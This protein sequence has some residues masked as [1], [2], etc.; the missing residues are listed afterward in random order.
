M[1]ATY[2]DDLAARGRAAWLSLLAEYVRDACGEFGSARGAL[3]LSLS[4]R[5]ARASVQWTGFPERVASCLGRQ[6]ALE[7]LDAE[8]P[9]PG[10]RELQ[11]EYVEWRVVRDGSRIARIEFTTELPDYWAL[12]AAYNPERLL[13]LV[14]EFA[15]A[16][17][18]AAEVFGTEDA[19]GDSVTRA[20]REDTFRAV[21]LSAGTS[22]FNDGRTAICCM[23]QQ[24]NSLFSAAALAAASLTPRVV[25]DPIDGRRRAPRCDEA[26]SLFWRG[27][28]Q[29]GRASDPLLVER[30]AQL[31]LEGRA[32]AFD[33]PVGIY[34]QSVALQ[35]LRTPDRKVPGREWLQFG[36]GGTGTDGQSRFQRLIFK[37]PPNSE[38][39]VSDLVDVATERPIA[40]GGEIADLLNLAVFFRVSRPG[41]IPIARRPVRLLP[42]EDSDDC[43]E[44]RQAYSA[45]QKARTQ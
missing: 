20:E 12:L 5:S 14:R 33:A 37:A 34:I 41:A 1:S 2:V 19:L 7:L 38:Y 4:N 15:E 3:R 10:G 36:R 31:A 8:P 44:I 17:V 22:P 24:S 16:E 11:E 39:C 27:V 18:D 35:R 26:V 40:Y 23:R 32:V 28:A 21:M 25:A 30:L 42:V 29:L 6:R 13:T 45:L 43:A 9:Y